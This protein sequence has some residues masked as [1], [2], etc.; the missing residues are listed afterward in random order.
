MTEAV[1]SSN[2]G[3]DSSG[4]G[5][6]ETPQ[7]KWMRSTGWGISGLIIAFLLFDS[8][9]KLALE[10]HV[11]EAATKIGYPVELLRPLGVICLVCTILYAVPRT[12]VL[13]AILL[14]GYLGGAI[15]SKVRIEDPLF[16]SVLFGLYFGL[17]VWGGLYLRDEQP[18][19][20]I[21]LRRN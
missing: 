7:P 1:H 13:G 16:S 12:A 20:R 6:E 18:R 21:P 2:I 5:L 17:L 3:K 9:S 11:V 14:T 4:S 19:G 15:A 8:I 10:R